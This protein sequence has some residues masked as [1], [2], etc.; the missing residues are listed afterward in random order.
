M[1]R[2]SAEIT[3]ST[4]SDLFIYGLACCDKFTAHRLAHL[5]LVIPL[6]AC[7]TGELVPALPHGSLRERYA[8]VWLPFHLPRCSYRG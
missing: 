4:E 7:R 6:R 8:P 1:G 2:G 3:C 5:R